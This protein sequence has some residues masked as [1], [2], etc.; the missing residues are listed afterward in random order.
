MFAADNLDNGNW[1]VDGGWCTGPSL[2]QAAALLAETGDALPR[3]LVKL[4]IISESKVALALSQRYALPLCPPGELAIDGD[5]QQHYSAAFLRAHWALPLNQNDGRVQVAV[6]DP[7]SEHLLRALQ[8]AIA[9][10]VDLAVATYSAIEAALESVGGLR[11][12]TMEPSSRV[13]AFDDENLESL[14][15]LAS[16][17]PVVR[18]VQRLI[19]DAMEARASDIHFEP[20]EVGLQVRYRVDGV[21]TDVDLAPREMRSAIVSRLKILAGLNI[22]ERRLPQDG[23]MRV[24]VQGRDTDFRVS[25]APTV[26]GESVVLRIL[27]RD[28]VA[29]DF[30]VLGFDTEMMATLRNALSRPYGIL[31]CTGPTG[32]GKTTTL[33][34]ALKELN[35]LDRKILTVEDPVEYTLAGINQTHVKPAIGYTFATAL[36]AFLRQD[37]DILMVGEIRDRET[38]EIASQAALTGHLLLSTLHTNTAA[39]AITRLLDMGID[40]YLLTSTL[41]LIIGQRL[42]RRLCVDCREPYRVP[43]E[44]YARFGLPEDTPTSV[45]RARGCSACGGTGY[46]GRTSILELLSLTPA[47]QRLVLQRAD[48][49]VL[50]EAAVAIGMRTMF[51]HGVTKVLA[52]ETTFDD[53]LRVT[54]AA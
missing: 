51:Q 7:T 17:A 46:L 47:L 20:R 50:E 45:Y 39:A 31:L 43:D 6:A 13:M 52:G 44:L 5:L 42:V 14:R 40:D 33:Y 19:T 32:S 3:A 35:T 25:T 1:W 21:L 53:V 26:F 27:D 16:N 30:Q 34:A 37:P 24:T 2:A 41:A 36:R 22:A 54:R 10:P 11:D 12:D 9:Q 29:L 8:F 4:G 15:D 38:A 23:R 48:A 49:R 18:R 28:Q